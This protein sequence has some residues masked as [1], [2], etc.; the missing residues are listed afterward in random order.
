MS[1]Y[2][3]FKTICW[4]FLNL[5]VNNLNDKKCLLVLINILW[6]HLRCIGFGVIFSFSRCPDVSAKSSHSVSLNL[7]G[8][9]LE[10]YKNNTCMYIPIYVFNLQFKLIFIVLKC[11]YHLSKLHEHGYYS[12]FLFNIRYNLFT[13]F[14]T[15][16]RRF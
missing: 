14:C 2:F 16:K 12:C 11:L 3:N 1:F 15:N 9:L 7:V 8:T 13:L 6:I 4:S 5:D 10:I